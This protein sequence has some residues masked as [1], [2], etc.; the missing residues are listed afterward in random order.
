[1]NYCSQQ[2]LFKNFL[3]LKIHPIEHYS[4][5]LNVTYLHYNIHNQVLEEEKKKY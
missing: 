2:K 1:M 5:Y 4:D 3:N